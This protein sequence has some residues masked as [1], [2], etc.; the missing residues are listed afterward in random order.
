M[1]FRNQNQQFNRFL[2]VGMMLLALAGIARFSV[3]HHRLLSPALGDGLTGL[4]Y[5]LAL[6]CIFLGFRQNRRQCRTNGQLGD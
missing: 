3:E 2:A 1:A 4:L 5:G 6:G